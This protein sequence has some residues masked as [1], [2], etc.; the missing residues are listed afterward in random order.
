M[1][2]AQPKMQVRTRLAQI[3]DLSFIESFVERFAQHGTPRWR[4]T[5]RMLQ[6]HQRTIDNAS[7]ALNTSDELLLIAESHA[8]KRLGFI[9][10]TH[11]LDVFTNEPQGYISTLAVV[12]EV[13]GRSIGQIL[14]AQAEQWAKQQGFRLLALDT[15]ATNTRARTFYQQMGYAEETIKFIKEL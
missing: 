3:G 11:T 9:H 14:M 10:A 15:F 7:A 5:A 6:F 1:T 13:E 4:D 12:K 8:G 2:R